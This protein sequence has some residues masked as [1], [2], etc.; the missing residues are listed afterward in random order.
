MFCIHYTNQSISELNRTKSNSLVRLR[1][2]RSII[3]LTKKLC[4]RFCSNLIKRLSS[5]DVLFHLF[6][7]VTPGIM[8][9]SLIFISFNFDGSV[10]IYYGYGQF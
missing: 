1:S 8:H 10:S 2:I 3:E 7:L 6:R 4:I 9:F 5:I